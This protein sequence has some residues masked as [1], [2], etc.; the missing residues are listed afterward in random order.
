MVIA[1]QSVYII[2]LDIF[3]GVVVYS[4]TRLQW[5]PGLMI[6]QGSVKIILLNRDIVIAEFPA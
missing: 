1:A 4:V 5:N 3:I 2:H 6:C